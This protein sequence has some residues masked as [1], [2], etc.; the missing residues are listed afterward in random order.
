MA[1]LLEKSWS[2]GSPHVVPFTYVSISF[3]FEPSHEIVVLFVLHKLILQNRMRSYSVRL[4]VW[5]LVRPFVY[6][7]TSYV[8]TARLWAF[9]G[10]LCDKYHNLMSWLIW[11]L[12]RDMDFDCISF[13]LIRCRVYFQCLWHIILVTPME[14]TL[15]R[16]QFN[17]VQSDL[18]FLP[19]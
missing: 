16:N 3:L 9:A 10:R 1:A 7:H 2:P 6:F 17:L 13:W 19:Y 18:H 4:D 5:F 12:W 11:C 8:W 15:F 14:G